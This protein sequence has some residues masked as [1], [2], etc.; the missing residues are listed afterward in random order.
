MIEANSHDDLITA[1]E[2][3][4]VEPEV[5]RELPELAPVAPVEDYRPVGGAEIARYLRAKTMG[6][7][8]RPSKAEV[9]AF[10]G[11]KEA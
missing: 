4:A 9:D 3:A 8:G 5:V 7:E 11:T 1:D 10:L 6:L 2:P